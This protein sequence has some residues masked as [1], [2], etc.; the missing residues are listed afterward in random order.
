MPDSP[1]KQSDSDQ[2]AAPGAAV[3]AAIGTTDH[4]L[5]D[6]TEAWSTL[7][8]STKAGI[9]AMLEAVG[10]TEERPSPTD[11]GSGG[12]NSGTGG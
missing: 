10:W 11:D 7:P 2:G 12:R 6:L 8:E 5:A 3:G 4:R 1:E 9:L